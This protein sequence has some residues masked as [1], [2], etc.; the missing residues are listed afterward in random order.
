MTFPALHSILILMQLVV[1]C[2]SIGFSAKRFQRDLACLTA[3]FF[4]FALI[5]LLLSDCYWI[6]YEVIRPDF[7]MPFAANEIGEWA[8]FLLLATALA[9]AVSGQGRE[10]MS[11][12]RDL[13]PALFFVGA[14]TALWIAW[15]GEWVQDILTG[16]VLTYFFTITLHAL[17]VT[18]ALRREEWIVLALLAAG[19]IGGQALTFAV[20]EKIRTVL[21]AGCYFLMFTGI[22]LAFI[23]T[24]RAWRREA[25]ETLFSLC[26]GAFCWGISCLYMSADPLYY[27][28]GV[29]VT[30]IIVF[31]TGAVGKVADRNDLC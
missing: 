11:I 28:V 16:I 26:C 27:A 5:C 14:S 19:L 1:L 15:S 29:A 25:P 10:P 17:R 4:A 18:G 8:F 2:F 22:I 9:T 31:Q 3:L 30:G 21:D 6:A 24:L 7:R 20:P 12:R 23:K 13:L